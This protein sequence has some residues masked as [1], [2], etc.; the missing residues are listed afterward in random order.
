MDQQNTSEGQIQSTSP[1]STNP[2]VFRTQT[3]Q[4]LTP[5]PPRLAQGLVQRK[6]LIGFWRK[7]PDIHLV[8]TGPSTYALYYLIA[9]SKLYEVGRLAKGYRTRKQGR[10][11]S[12]SGLSDSKFLERYP[13]PLGCQYG[14]V[15]KTIFGGFKSLCRLVT[16]HLLSW[17][18]YITSLSLH[19]P[20]CK[21]GINKS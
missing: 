13:L 3:V 14:T 17:A 21:M 12:N 10:Q 18:T 16:L 4:Y 6:H 7:T 15:V 8:L 11:D 1:R 19:F 2:L 20:I 9:S 5:S